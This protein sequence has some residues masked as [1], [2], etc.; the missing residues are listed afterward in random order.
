MSLDAGFLKAILDSPDDDGP[1]LVYADWLDEH[2]ESHRAE[3]IRLQ[4]G[5][6]RLAPWDPRRLKPR[7]REQGLLGRHGSTWAGGLR[8]YP[9]EFRRGLLEHIALDTVT[10]FLGSA[11]TLFAHGPALNSVSLTPGHPLRGGRLAGWP[12]LSRFRH[13]TVRT[14]GLNSVRPYP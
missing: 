9:Y 13:L 8:R 14:R 3:F 12:E 2:G 11:D 7:A 5:L 10:R 4:V 1:R 6:A